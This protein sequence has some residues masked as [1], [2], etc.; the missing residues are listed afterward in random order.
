MRGRRMAQSGE[1]PVV[2]DRNTGPKAAYTHGDW[3]A[4]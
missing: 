2:M 3:Q 4:Y 1:E